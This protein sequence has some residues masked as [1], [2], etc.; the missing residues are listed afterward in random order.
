[1]ATD[2]EPA[3]AEV[4]EQVIDKVSYVEGSSNLASY[5]NNAQISVSP[6]DFTIAFGQI[7]EV[8]DAKLIVQQRATVVMSPEHAKA[9]ANV[10]NNNIA[11]YEKAFGEIR[12]SVDKK[13]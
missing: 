7:A 11:S 1:M 10:L 6:W 8:K 2:K 3:E 13:S 4:Q 12:W 5:V 9:L